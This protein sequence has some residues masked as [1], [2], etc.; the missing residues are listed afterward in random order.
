MRERNKNLGSNIAMR[1]RN[2]NLVSNIDSL[3]CN[4]PACSRKQE[5]STE[6]EVV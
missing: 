5:K 1:E 2:K 6:L 3:P 4:I